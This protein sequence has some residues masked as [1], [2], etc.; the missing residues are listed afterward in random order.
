MDIEK[1]KH[2]DKARVLYELER[3]SRSKKQK[4]KSTS[5]VREKKKPDYNIFEKPKSKKPEDF[6]SN[7]FLKE[8]K[9]Y[10]H[11]PEA[12]KSIRKML[13]NKDAD[14]STSSDEED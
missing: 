4:E 3:L 6:F 9:D 14:D 10:I 11:D 1:I 8:L 5:K 7:E 2:M 13:K 12:K